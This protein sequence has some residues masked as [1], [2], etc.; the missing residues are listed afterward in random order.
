MVEGVQRRI[1]LRDEL[2]HVLLRE[3]PEGAAVGLAELH[4]AGAV[5]H[6]GDCHV[7][8]GGRGVLGKGEDGV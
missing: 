5:E 4:V 7:A 3:A 1:V 2:D 6:A 8:R